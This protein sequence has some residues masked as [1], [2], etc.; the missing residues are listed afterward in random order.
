MMGGPFD[1]MVRWSV[2]KLKGG[3]IESHCRETH[4][5]IKSRRV[6]WKGQSVQT[7]FQGKL[8]K[9][10]PVTKLCNPLTSADHLIKGFLEEADERDIEQQR[11]LNKVSETQD[12]V[13]LTPWLRR[14]GWPRM[15]AGKFFVI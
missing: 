12:F 3:S 4:G 7:F 9:Y 6:T 14:T 5:W 13:T 2:F 8:V 11:A 10:F 1:G 15:F